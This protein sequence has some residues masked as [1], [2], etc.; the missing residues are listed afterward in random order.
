[1]GAKHNIHIAN[2]VPPYIHPSEVITALH[3]H[4]T[5]LALQA[6]TTGHERLPNTAQETLKDT[7]WYPT[8]IY[9]VDT[10]NVT[11][12]VTFL[13]GMRQWGKKNI[14]FPA[15][16]QN[17]PT[18]LRTRADVSGV[19]LRAE[20]RVMKSNAYGEVEGEGQGIGGAEWVLVEDAEISCSQWLMPLVKDKMEQAHREICHKVI[21]KIEM[22][23]RQNNLAKT[24][25][26]GKALSQEHA[27]SL[28]TI[29]VE[30]DAT[31]MHDSELPES[32]SEKIIYG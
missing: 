19:V 16:F 22:Q 17:T 15:C 1:M 32:R 11:E 7:Y 28:N 9:P 25:G 3:D 21:E 13:P 31:E 6:L 5:V 2:L 4:N 30:T 27:L 12:C 26:R 10:Y 23:R 18:G 14:T 8:D 24:V 29:L 20:Y